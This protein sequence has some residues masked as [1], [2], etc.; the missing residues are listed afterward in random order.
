MM[1]M[2]MHLETTDPVRYNCYYKIESIVY[3]IAVAFALSLG[4]TFVNVIANV[5]FNTPYRLNLMS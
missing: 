2:D 4:K 1:K 5:E 3:S